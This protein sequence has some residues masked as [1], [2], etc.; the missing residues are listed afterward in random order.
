M[1][2]YCQPPLLFPR[3]PEQFLQ[4]GFCIVVDAHD[5]DA[6]HQAHVPA[7]VGDETAGVVYDVLLPL[8]VGP[9]SDDD[10]EYQLLLSDAVFDMILVDTNTRILTSMGQSPWDNIKILR[11][12]SVSICHYV[13]LCVLNGT[14]PNILGCPML[15][16]ML[17]NKFGH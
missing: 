2:K 8:F 12:C 7:D 1:F 11:H 3:F 14:I 9:L 13:C 5:A 16:K 10:L 4:E 17:V 15:I 6:Q